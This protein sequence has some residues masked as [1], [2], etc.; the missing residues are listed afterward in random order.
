[1]D[2]INGF[3][4]GLRNR[5]IFIIFFLLSLPLLLV[6][7]L[8]DQSSQGAEAGTTV[9][10]EPTPG[11][12][13][14]PLTPPERTICDPF[15]TNSPSAQD[16]GVVA[17]MVWLDDTMPPR[18]GQPALAHTS[19]YFT[20]GNVVQST[21]YFDRIF[22]PTR[23]FDLGFFTQ[24]GQVVLNYLGQPMYEYFALHM[25]GQ[26]QLGALD[27]AGD[28]QIAVL[29]DDGAVLKVSDGNGGYTTIVDNDGDHSTK[30]GCP[31]QTV[32]MEKTT[33]LPFVLEYHQGPRYHIAV[34]VLWRPVPDGS[35]PSIPVADTQCGR[36]GNSMYWNSTV[37]PSQA[38]QPFY[39]LLARGW[40]V[41]ENENYYFPAQAIN[42]CVPVE[43]PLAISSFQVVGVSR[44]S[45]T[46][47]WLTN[48]DSD[49]QIEIRNV[50]T[51]AIARTALDSTNVSNHTVVVSG[52]SPNTLYAF[53]GIS[54]SPGGQTAVS[55]ER[56]L[57]TLR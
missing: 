4:R 54:V 36:Q 22:V 52:L 17:N 38:Q 39:E 55:D 45:V 3:L 26:F 48:V 20:I 10:N 32:H 50:A 12:P 7:C 6:S 11:Q 19:D 9:V 53:K 46:L 31:T 21:L 43:A 37:V 41:L 29:A 27:P 34:A 30:M 49:S 40:K 24:D 51:G 56:A 2:T 28:Y 25:E 14:S 18:N 47:N 8:G 1:M 57:R 35:D 33:K 16:R 5:Q 42:P 13:L 23:A 15:N 44:T